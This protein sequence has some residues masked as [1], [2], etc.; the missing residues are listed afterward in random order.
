MPSSIRPLRSDDIGEAVRLARAFHAA[1]AY[2]G[3]PLSIAKVDALC[4]NAIAGGDYFCVVLDT[5]DGLGGY[6][7]GIAYEHHFSTER[8]VSDLGFWIEPQHRSPF[9]ARAMLA[10]L[11]RW[12]F[13]VKQVGTLNLGVSS[14][15]ADADV[16]RF[17]RLLGYS[18][19]FTG[20]IK[21]AT[22]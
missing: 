17:Y 22:R 7:M 10:E 4:Q 19:T 18:R 12:A 14:G 3:L 9:A 2:A 8:T 11:E 20:M 6:L 13:H 15:I 21:D 16:V 1:S 5:G